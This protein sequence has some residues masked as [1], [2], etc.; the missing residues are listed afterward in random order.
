MMGTE[1]VLRLTVAALM[2][3]TGERQTDLAAGIGQAQTQVSR[4]QSGRAHWSLEDVDLLAA[5]YRLHPLDLLAGP[6]HAAGVLHGSIASLQTPGALPLPATAAERPS[7]AIAAV[8]D[9]AA[10][11]PAA[12]EHEHSAATP[13]AGPCVLCGQPAQHELDGFPQHLTAE[14]CAAAIAAASTTQAS[15]PAVEEVPAPV[16]PAE[17]TATATEETAATTS[18]ETSTAGA[19]AEEPATAADPT[20]ADPVAAT[21]PT[22][23]AAAPAAA[24]VAAPPTAPPTAPAAAPPTAPVAASAAK[25]STPGYASTTLVEQISGRVHEVLEARSGDTEAAQADLIKRAIPD[26]MA[27]LKASRVGGR[28]EHSEF[29]P[30]QEILRKKS[31]KGADEIWE[32]RPKWRNRELFAAARGGEEIEVTA[33]DMNAAYLSALKCWLP[34]GQLREDT[35]GV[36]DPK[37]AGVHLITPA[38]WDHPDLPNPLGN[39]IEPGELWVSESTL[40]LLLDCARQGLADAPLIHRSLISGASEALLEKLR[41]ALAESRKTALAEGDEVTVAYVKAMYSKFVSTIG[42]SSANRELRRPDWMHIIRAKAFA[43]LWMKAH[44]AK[45][46][47][48]KV[49]EISGTDELHV[50]GDWRP[51]FP[52]G[53][54]LNQVKEKA[55]YILGGQR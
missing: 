15:A 36:H 8:L 4:K 20:T 45:K 34:I 31:Q 51:V 40:R 53:R 28:Y 5:H 21:A 32:G 41:R 35:S 50:V 11:T 29:P 22:A 19:P 49:V 54:D 52:E 3:R 18:E 17:E 16:A 25:R 48:L 43:N 6:T 33:L 7:P 1:E 14:E 55:A 42:E 47:G 27:L 23:P 39:R 13:E 30:T 26:V 2:T 37:K 9:Q 44:R 46:A 38:D 24:P 10:T 12:V